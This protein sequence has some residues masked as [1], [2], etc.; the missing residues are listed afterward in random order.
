MRYF[1]TLLNFQKLPSPLIFEFV[2]LKLRDLFKFW[3]FKQF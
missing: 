1:S 2:D 3:F